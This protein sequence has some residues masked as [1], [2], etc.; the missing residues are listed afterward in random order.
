MRLKTEDGRVVVRFE[1][2]LSS[3][4]G[5]SELRRWVGAL[6]SQNALAYM[7]GVGPVYEWAEANAVELKELKYVVDFAVLKSDGRF[8]Q[9][10][11]SGCTFVMNSKRE[12]GVPKM[13]LD[14]RENGVLKQLY[15]GGEDLGAQIA[16]FCV[17]KVF[18]AHHAQD[19]L[20]TIQDAVK[21]T[22][23]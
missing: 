4:A 11:R 9:V 5:G 16:F 12:R 7:T 10:L 22:R 6:K 1:G 2:V 21:R 14:S 20:D 23:P 19:A 15:E 8:C 3:R 18:A 13:A 17:G